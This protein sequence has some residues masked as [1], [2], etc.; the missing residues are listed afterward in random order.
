MLKNLTV[1]SYIS[2]F[3][4]EIQARLNT[5]REIFLEVLPDTEESISYKIPCYTVGNNNL[6]FAGYK[7][8]IGFYPVYGFE[9][10]EDEL[11]HFRAKGTKNSLHFLHSKPL[12][13][14]LI[15]KIIQLKALE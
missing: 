2:A 15:T 5:L 14:A 6:Y 8:H 3:D 7:K 13:I 12:P 11:S 9:E 4:P 1:D 10:I